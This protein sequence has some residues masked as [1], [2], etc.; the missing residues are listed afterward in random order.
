VFVCYRMLSRRKGNRGRKGQLGTGIPTFRG[1][2]RIDSGGLERT[3]IR[4][5]H[6]YQS[7]AITSAVTTVLGAISFTLSGFAGYSDLVQVYDQY[8]II[9]VEVKFLPQQTQI[10]TGVVTNGN[11]I[12]A[13]DYDD[14]NV[15][16]S[17]TVLLGFENCVITRNVVQHVRKLVPRVAV[18]VYGGAFG[19]YGNAT[20]WID[21][22]SSAVNYY[23]LKYAL[24]GS[25]VLGQI[26]DAYFSA[27]VEFRGRRL[28]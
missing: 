26:T 25:T 3:E 8:R 10:T 13:V 9:E 7:A 19:A 20:P 28:T 21:S 27:K 23:G 15:P 5:L 2:Q 11:L 1:V 17:L 18:N 14:A 16:G 6:A 4:I 24:T 12:T 22:V